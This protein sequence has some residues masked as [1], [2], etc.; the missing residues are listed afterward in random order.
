[1]VVPQTLILK[2]ISCSKDSLYVGE[3]VECHFAIAI[4]EFNV[5]CTIYQTPSSFAVPL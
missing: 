4:S 5:G 3:A 1:M 2:Q